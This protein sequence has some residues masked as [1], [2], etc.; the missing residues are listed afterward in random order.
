MSGPSA[1]L[2]ASVGVVPAQ[3]ELNRNLRAMCQPECLHHNAHGHC[4][5]PWTP[6]SLKSEGRN[7]GQ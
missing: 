5:N 1:S 4:R 6:H 7:S 2:I 3:G